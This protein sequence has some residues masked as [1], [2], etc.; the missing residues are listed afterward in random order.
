MLGI[1]GKIV[2]NVESQSS[3]TRRTDRDQQRGYTLTLCVQIS[4]TRFDQIGTGQTIFHIASL[5]RSRRIVRGWGSRSCR[6]SRNQLLREHDEWLWI[7]AD[8]DDADER[9]NHC[10]L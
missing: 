1:L 4:E 7:D 3:K 6:D 8:N 2:G 9:G 5:L 10:G